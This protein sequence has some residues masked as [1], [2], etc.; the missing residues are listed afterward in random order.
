[1]GETARASVEG[2]QK[3]EPGQRRR[4][5]VQADQRSPIR[6]GGNEIGVQRTSVDVRNDHVGRQMAAV[7]KPDAADPAAGGLDRGDRCRQT[8]HDPTVQRALVKGEAESAQATPDVPRAERLLD[9]GNGGESSRRAARVGPGVGGV[10]V[11]HRAQVWIAQIATAEAAQGA[12]RRD[13]AEV[14]D[15]ARLAQQAAHAVQRRLEERAAGGVPDA[16]GPIHEPGPVS[17]RPGPERCVQRRRHR[18]AGAVG[19]SQLDAVREAVVADR[20][21]R[22]Q[23]DLV[24]ERSAGLEEQVAIDRRQGQQRRPGVER[25]AVTVEPA[26]LAAD[27]GRL[28]AGRHAMAERGQPRRRG[29]PAHAGPDDDDLGHGRGV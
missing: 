21:D 27:V 25:E 3:N 19:Q 12:P 13:R 5:A 29:E 4:G 1:M 20:V 15:L 7:G 11:Q 18:A 22:H 16:T 28:L 9:V 6:L 26:E 14:G 8:D 24:L 23:V 10:A 17:A 2:E